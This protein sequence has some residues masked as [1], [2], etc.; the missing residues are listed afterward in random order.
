[1]DTHHCSIQFVVTA[2]RLLKYCL[3][4]RIGPVLNVH[5]KCY[6][7]SDYGALQIEWQTKE[8]AQLVRYDDIPS[9][10]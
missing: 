3:L 8:S 5:L 2:I 9:C 4:V 10:T 7:F 1:M 6:K